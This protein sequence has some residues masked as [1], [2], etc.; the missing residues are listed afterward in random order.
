MNAVQG[1]EREGGS[2][3]VYMP[4][5]ERHVDVRREEVLQD[6][7]VFVRYS[8]DGY[9]GVELVL[10]LRAFPET[11]ENV[12]H[13]DYLLQFKEDSVDL[14]NYRRALEIAHE[15]SDMT[16]PVI[17]LRQCYELASYTDEEI[18]SLGNDGIMR[19][20]GSQGAE[21]IPYK[22]VLADLGNGDLGSGINSLKEI[23]QR[24][25]S[26]AE[27]PLLEIQRTIVSAAG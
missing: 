9:D 12:K 27:H 6:S 17:Q 4:Q 26:Q 21:E 14:E 25:Y 5:K 3:T 13:I 7:S 10:G 24:E 15:L 19:G 23:R 2:C 16:W 11:P 1:V 22:D 20:D 18:N 8:Q